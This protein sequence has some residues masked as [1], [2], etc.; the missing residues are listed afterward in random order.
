MTKQFYFKQFSLAKFNQ[1]KWFQV[2]LCIT[3]NSI[4]HKLFVCTPL[5]DHTVLFQTIQFSISHLLALS[6]NIK[7]FYLTHCKDPIG[8]QNF[9]PEWTW[10]RW[11]WRSILHS[12][13]LLHDWSLTI[14]LFWR[15]P[16]CNG[17]RHRIWTRRY[18]FNSW[19]RLI[20]FHIALIPLG[21]VW[22][23]LFSLQLWVNSRAD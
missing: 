2:L 3:N 18:E 16:W 22:I 5:N 14:R 10:G 23:Q 7:Q 1:V 20:T 21:K 19:T 9:G 11:K 6:L 15:C 17:Y 12:P 8:Y 4:K 13:K